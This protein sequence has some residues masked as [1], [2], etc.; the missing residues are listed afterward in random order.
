MGYL[1]ESEILYTVFRE[2]LNIKSR[3]KFKTDFNYLH[4]IETNQHDC[5]L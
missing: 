5:K 1:L 4:K 2:M 3:V